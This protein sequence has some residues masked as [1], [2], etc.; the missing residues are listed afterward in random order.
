MTAVLFEGVQDVLSINSSSSTST[1]GGSATFTGNV[2]PDKAGH[3]IYLQRLGSDG[4]WHTVATGYVSPASDFQFQW[5]FGTPGTKQFRAQITGGP[6][7]VGGASAPTTVVVT[8][9]A[10]SSL[11]TTS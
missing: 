1:V 10:V 6:A 4:N 5:T 11:P 9:P 3:V 8:L 2:S 7:N